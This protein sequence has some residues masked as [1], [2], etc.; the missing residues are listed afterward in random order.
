M[1]ITLR[2]LSV[3]ISVC[4]YPTKKTS[5]NANDS[6]QQ[7]E[8]LLTHSNSVDWNK[9]S[10]FSTQIKLWI[11]I[12]HSIWACAC[13]KDFG[14]VSALIRIWPVFLGEGVDAVEEWLG[15]CGL[16]TNYKWFSCF[17]FGTIHTHIDTKTQWP[18]EAVLIVWPQTKI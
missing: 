13:N 17:F 1:S 18:I 6:L 3:F 11:S 7:N 9:T 10:F 2:F 8:V 16:Q 5:L 12:E 15:V 4:L 14:F